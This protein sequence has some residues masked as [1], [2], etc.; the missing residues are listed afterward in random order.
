MDISGNIMEPS[1]IRNVTNISQLETIINDYNENFR[2]Y[3]RNLRDMLE[4]YRETINDERTRRLE[5]QQRFHTN[6]PIRN[7]N[8]MY[9]LRNDYINQPIRNWNNMYNLRNDYINNPLSNIIYNNLQDVVVRPTNEEITFATETVIYDISMVDNRCPISLEPFEPDDLICRIKHCGHLFKRQHLINWFGRNV[10]CPV[11]RF[12][13]RTYR[14]EPEGEGEAEAESENV[15]QS[16]VSENT[17]NNFIS[18]LVRNLITNEMNRPSNINNTLND[19][20][21]SF[22]IPLEIDISYNNTH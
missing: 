3:N 7:T 11:C 13:I 9:N 4:I 14:E 8:N 1:L 15:V 5:R 2:Y 10:R 16:T 18:T 17:S 6:P 12:D 21:V 20:F 22:S 19:F